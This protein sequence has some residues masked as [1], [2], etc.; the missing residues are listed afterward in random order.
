MEI[1]WGLKKMEKLLAT[2]AWFGD[3]ISKVLH[4]MKCGYHT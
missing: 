2:K 3:V 1:R 4:L